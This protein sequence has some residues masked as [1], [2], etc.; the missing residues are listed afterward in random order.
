MFK[1]N[2]FITSWFCWGNWRE[3]NVKF[4]NFLITFPLLFA[5]GPRIIGAIKREGGVT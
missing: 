3:I 2:N 5:K 4:N 1:F